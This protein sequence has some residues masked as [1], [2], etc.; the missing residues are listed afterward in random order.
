MPQQT[1]RLPVS[2]L[3]R[4][5][6]VLDG[7]VYRA[8]VRGEGVVVAGARYA[9][10]V[11]VDGSD[12]DVPVGAA[13]SDYLEGAEVGSRERDG[14]LAGALVLAA[15]TGHPRVNG[16]G[17]PAEFVWSDHVA[18]A[19]RGDASACW[20]YTRVREPLA[21]HVSELRGRVAVRV[22][23]GDREPAGG[24]GRP[25]TRKPEPS[26][27]P[28]EPVPFEV[29]PDAVDRGRRGHVLTENALHDAIEAAGFEAREPA[30]GEPP[31][32]LAWEDGDAIVVA[33]A[34][35]VT[36]ANE[37]LQLRLGLG[38]LLDYQSL[39]A[40]GGREVRA[41]LVLEREPGDP[42]WVE[43]CRRHGVRLV[44]PEVFGELF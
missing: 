41:V 40:G 1:V 26:A 17:R 5:E 11:R 31:Y 28:A 44:W 33:E 23:A 18:L 25:R 30:P 35:S 34:K 13:V 36:P 29:D 22:A 24:L 42:R 21:E 19:H 8:A 14:I 12:L 39:L 27:S 10:P 9:A 16:A 2:T 3:D 7:T 20:R 6:V 4:V 15:L 43:L 37:L 32:D 38:Q